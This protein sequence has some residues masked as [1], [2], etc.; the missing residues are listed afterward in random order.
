MAESSDLCKPLKVAIC[1]AGIGTQHM[2]AYLQLPD[3]FHVQTVCD[4][5]LAK[6]QALASQAVNCQTTTDIDSVLNDPDIDVIDICLPPHLHCEMA[7]KA[8]AASKHVICEKPLANSLADADRL[9]QAARGSNRVLVPVFQYRYGHAFEQLNALLEAGLTGKPLVASLECHWNRGSDYYAIPWRGT[10]AGEQGG[11]VL[12]HAIH[13]HDLL[14]MVMGPVESLSAMLTTRVN[15]IETED[16]AAISFKMAN[17]ALATSSITLGAANDTSRLRF[18]FEDLTAES[19]RNPYR[20][21]A[22]KWSFMARSPRQQKD[23]DKVLAGIAE[24]PNGY[25]GLFLEA[26]KV[27]NGAASKVVSMVDGRQSIELVSAIYQSARNQQLINLPLLNTDPIYY[28]WLD[29]S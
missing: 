1:G 3:Q 10:W 29:S 26:A 7:L 17:G 28:G 4:L 2:A 9:I 5:D 27:I 20:P 12:C 25:A 18:C 21:G 23:L 19:G 6:A 13:L 11:A 14:C 8:L 15:D 24:S 22:D 16:C